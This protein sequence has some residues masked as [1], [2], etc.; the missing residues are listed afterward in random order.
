MKQVVGISVVRNESDV[1]EVF[2]RYNLNSLDELHII[3]NDSSDNT[4]K[5]IRYLIDEGLPIF[6]SHSHKKNHSQE[7]KL[8][9]K[10][11][12]L[13]RNR[14]DISYI[15]PLDADELILSK[16][17]S[18]FVDDISRIEIETK[19]IGC[20]NMYWESHIPEC[21]V[22]SSIFY[23]QMSWVRK[24]PYIGLEMRKLVI[25]TYSHLNRCEISPGSHVLFDTV[26]QKT[27]L[28]HAVK[29][30]TRLG[31][32]PVRSYQ[33]IIR[34][35]IMGGLALEMK[36]SPEWEGWHWKELSNLI[37][38]QGFTLTV[39]QLREIAC[40]YSFKP[41]Q[42]MNVQIINN[43]IFHFDN[44]VVKYE[45]SPIDVTNDLYLLTTFLISLVLDKNLLND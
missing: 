16:N 9:E 8:T 4:V 40:F 14:T 32:F 13:V 27:S 10:M 5:I 38:S 33:Q 7:K 36:G 37:R 42:A 29:L 22:T 19:G 26:G 17:K 41:Q 2:C 23:E 3:D 34:K 31:H 44:V 25:P 21:S 43:P 1:I 39:E 18:D 12:E 24:L 28:M 11:H 20:G 35:I 30:R 6:L 45:Q 15:V